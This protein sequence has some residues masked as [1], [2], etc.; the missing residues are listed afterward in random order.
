MRHGGCKH[1]C[2]SIDNKTRWPGASGAVHVHAS[3]Y[4]HLEST[5]IW[6]GFILSDQLFHK[7]Y[8]A[9]A[10]GSQIGLL[11]DFR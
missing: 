7:L 1:A 11:N 2:S 3:K 9:I 4:R 8:P 6:T 5:N 10:I